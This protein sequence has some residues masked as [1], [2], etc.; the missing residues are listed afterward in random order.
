MKEGKDQRGLKEITCSSTKILREGIEEYKIKHLLVGYFVWARAFRVYFSL[1][2]K[3][4]VK[5][6]TKFCTYRRLEF[7]E[8]HLESCSNEPARWNKLWLYEVC[9]HSIPIHEKNGPSFSFVTAKW[10]FRRRSRAFNIIKIKITDSGTWKGPLA[11]TK[12]TQCSACVMLTKENFQIGSSIFKWF[13]YT[14]RL[15]QLSYIT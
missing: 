5:G 14:I 2:G 10:L 9:E 1:M 7:T 3:V 13:V 15:V 4:E 6:N 8:R 11:I 12:F